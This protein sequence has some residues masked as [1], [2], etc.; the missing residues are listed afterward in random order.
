MLTESLAITKVQP[1]TRYLW[2]LTLSY[3]MLIAL[4]NWFDARLV[5]LFNIVLSPGTLIFPL[6]F[7]LSNLITEV[8]GYKNTRRAVWTAFLFNLIFILFGQILTL[9]PSPSFAKDSAAFDRLFAM[10][11]LVIIGSLISYLVSESL[12]PYIIAKLKIKF[13]GKYMGIRFILSTLSASILDS[14][15]FTIIAFGV[16]YNT[17]ILYD[18]IINI[19][20]TKIVIEILG[21]PLSMRVANFLKKQEQL[22]IYDIGTNFTPLGLETQYDSRHNRYHQSTVK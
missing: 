9:L 19:S 14:A 15:I 3:S 20:V 10:N 1:S 6:S 17:T 18:L 16:T 8:Y 11:T 4:S 13:N 22:D 5:Q 2:F 7:L 21:L 12:N